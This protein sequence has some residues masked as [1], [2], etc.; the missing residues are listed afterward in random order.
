MG[1]VNPSQ[2][3]GLWL[4]NILLRKFD[5]LSKKRD[6]NVKNTNLMMKK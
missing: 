1:W 2:A 6:E 5:T 3:P 4:V